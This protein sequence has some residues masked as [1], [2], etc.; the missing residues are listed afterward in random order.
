MKV[1]S[2]IPDPY[3]VLAGPAEAYRRVPVVQR[4]TRALE[5]YAS[6]AGSPDAR[7]V[8]KVHVHLL[9]VSTGYDEVGARKRQARVL[10]AYAG[11]PGGLP[12]PGEELERDGDIPVP[13]EIHKSVRLSARVRV[14]AGRGST[15]EEPVSVEATE[16]V[17]QEDFDRWSYDYG[18]LF[19]LAIRRLVGR[20]GEIVQRAAGGG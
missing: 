19:D 10:L 15:L 17:Y 20:V 8:V 2:D 16:V 5:R 12:G 13:L 3:V 11:G 4:L 18:P 14:T 6:A 7:E 9:E 1:T